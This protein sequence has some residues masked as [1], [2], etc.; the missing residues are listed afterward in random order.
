MLT[1]GGV[2][3]FCVVLF[4]YLHVHY[5]LKTSN[6]LE[7]YELTSPSKETLEEICGLR[8]PTRLDFESPGLV[9][10]LTSI[11]SEYGPFDVRVR[12]TS[13]SLEEGEDPYVVMPLQD[14]LK[15]LENDDGGRYV[16]ENNAPFLEETGLHKAFSADD[17]YLRPYMV[18]NRTYD[19]LAGSRGASTPLR[20][21]LRYRTYFV[22]VSK[23]VSV[24]L[25][26]P[27]GDRYLYPVYDYCNFEFR[28]PVNP[29]SVQSTYEADFAKVKCLDVQLAPGQALFVPAYWWY[30]IKFSDPAA[31]VASFK[32][33]TYMSA[34]ATANHAFL[35]AL[36]SQNM[37]HTVPTQRVTPVAP[38]PKETLTI[39]EG[40]VD[41][42][43]AT[44]PSEPEP[45]ARDSDGLQPKTSPQE[46]EEREA[47]GI[48]V[49]PSSVSYAP[50]S[51]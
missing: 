36:Q 2:V 25:T 27:K 31:R 28:S 37:K 29:W 18:A 1:V 33:S 11:E 39:S 19:L 49:P 17:P 38:S 20:R 34:L 40:K 44:P 8:Q 13:A 12:D 51:P 42:E 16:T 10:R 9:K 32:Y 46:K 41:T 5:H 3:V 6:D 43:D 23:E 48:F 26:P 7:V 21:E 14:V 47:S 35:W 15:A 45:E 24:K 4:F 30:S 22:A 50:A